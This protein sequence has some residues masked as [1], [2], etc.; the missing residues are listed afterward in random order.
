MGGGKGPDGS[1]EQKETGPFRFSSAEG[2]EEEARAAFAQRKQQLED[3]I[4]KGGFSLAEMLR[5]YRA[6]QVARG[7]SQ[8]TQ[9][10]ENAIYGG[11]DKLLAGTD[12]VKKRIQK[13]EGAAGMHQGIQFD[14]SLSSA[15]FF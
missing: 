4:F 6:G 3:Q 1:Q 8:T 12:M 7:S 9:G 13:L 11:V 10:Y 2:S 14:T 5:G 15:N